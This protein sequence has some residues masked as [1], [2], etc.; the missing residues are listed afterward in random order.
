[1]CTRVIWGACYNAVSHSEPVQLLEG[2]HSPRPGGQ[3]PSPRWVQ[4]AAR[5]VR[6]NLL[7]CCPPVVPRPRS[8]PRDSSRHLAVLS[9]SLITLETSCSSSEALA[10]PRGVWLPSEQVSSDVP[11]VVCAACAIFS[12]CPSG[13]GSSIHVSCALH[14][15]LGPGF[16]ADS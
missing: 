13:P 6:A 5:G 2:R 12:T 1:M 4:G 10:Q 7:G 8:E 11:I 14:S 15:S 9:G 16:L 3:A